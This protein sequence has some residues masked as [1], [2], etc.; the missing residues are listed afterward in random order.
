V[1]PAAREA[2][3]DGLNAGSKGGRI[4]WALAGTLC[5]GKAQGTFA[6]KL[7]NCIACEFYQLVHTE[8][9][10]QIASFRDLQASR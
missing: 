4:C 10:K 2:S 3:A 1:C 6:Q 8:E 5:G 9:G 7:E